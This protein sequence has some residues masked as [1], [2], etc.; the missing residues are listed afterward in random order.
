MVDFLQWIFSGIL[1]G[2]IYACIAISFIVIYRS[3][4]VFNFAQGELVMMAGYLV[5][6]GAVIFNMPSWASII[7]GMAAC[8]LLG[9]IIE[10]FC[11]R[12]LVGQSLFSMLMVTIGVMLILRALSMLIWGPTARRFPDLFGE[13]IIIGPFMFTSSLFYGFLLVALL[14][15]ALWW[16]FGHTRR[17]LTLSAVA[18]GHDVAR[19]LGISVKQSISLAWVIAGIISVVAAISW[20]SG[21]SINYMVADVGLRAMP[22]ALLAGLE[23]IPG[24]LLA[25]VI[26]GICESLAVGYLDTYTSGGMSL[27]MPFLIMLIVLWVRPQGM[28]G[29]KII[30]RL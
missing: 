22:C 4:K 9:L 12:P 2:G 15:V 17:G 29:W 8:A 21:R 19:S 7:F 24:A 6:T 20:L 30:E 27:I 3:S 13:T 18:E 1:L 25:G 28:F 11:I 5:F 14:T 10:R 23:S 26:V 16:M